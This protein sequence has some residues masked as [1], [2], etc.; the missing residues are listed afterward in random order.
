MPT[1]SPVHRMTHYMRWADDAM[2]RNAERLP[3]S[4]LSAPRTALLSSVRG[5]FDH[6]LVVAEIFLAHL[7]G[8][9]HPHTARTRHPSPPFAEVAARLRA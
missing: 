2:L 6:T 4:D 3:P 9:T 5:T 7:T 8:V 1:C